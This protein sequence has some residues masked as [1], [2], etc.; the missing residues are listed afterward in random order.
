MITVGGLDNINVTDYCDW[1][2]KSVAIYDLTE[3]ESV[4]WGSVFSADKAPYQ[5]NAQVSAVIGGGPNGGATKLL[6]DGGWSSTLVASLLTGTTNQ[7]AP[8][9]I[10]GSATIL[11]SSTSPNNKSTRK[12][13]IV[14]GVVG[15]IG[16]IVTISA[17]IFLARRYVKKPRKINADS[18]QQYLKSEMDGNGIV[19]YHPRQEV[20]EASPMEMPPSVYQ[21]HFETSG[22]PRSEV[23]GG[24]IPAEMAGCDVPEKD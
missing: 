11:A 9:P 23:C 20:V 1:E 22:N 6:P 8:V 13:A 7:T 15:G 16:A 12:A 5:V 17:V 2:Y 18:Q 21:T 10:S 19:R 3:G 4:G 24:Q 14:G